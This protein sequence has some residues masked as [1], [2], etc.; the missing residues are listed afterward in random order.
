MKNP[1]KCTVS[2]LAS[3]VYKNSW[4]MQ[5]LYALLIDLTNP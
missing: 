2:T 1:Q 3:K 4:K 5:S